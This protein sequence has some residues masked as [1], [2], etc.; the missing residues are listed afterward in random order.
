MTGGKPL[1][2]DGITGLLNLHQSPR[3]FLSLLGDR[4]VS[5]WLKT[6]ACCGLVYSFSPLDVVPDFI[7]G[8]GL[9]DDLIVALLIMQTFVTL[10]PRVVVEEHCAKLHIDP[11]RLYVDVPR[12][13]QDAIAL[14]EMSQSWL[15]RNS[16][17]APAPAAPAPPSPPPVP[18][19]GN[20][21]D[22]QQPAAPYSRYSAYRK[23]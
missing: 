11:E 14:Y 10:A 12:T 22:Q 1:K 2:V 3:V 17:A 13:V 6:C 18:T 5:L 8:I 15:K 19:P 21:A 4:R 23:G 7:T 9:L 20:V 16:E